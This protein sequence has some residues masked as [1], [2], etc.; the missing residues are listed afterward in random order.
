[1]RILCTAGNGVD[2]NWVEEA[3]A[4]PRSIRQESYG[5]KP[6]QSQLILQQ[7]V[8]E[9]SDTMV[10]MKYDPVID[11][12]SPSDE[13][14]VKNRLQGGHGFGICNTVRTED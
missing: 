7:E 4:L 11:T 14:K 13:T 6:W 12:Y 10:V 1:M 3:P 8:D 9:D 2:G 5:Y